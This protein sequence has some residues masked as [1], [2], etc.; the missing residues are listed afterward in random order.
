MA[1]H[2]MLQMMV[3]F[4]FINSTSFKNTQHC[5]WITGNHSVKYI[6]CFEEVGSCQDVEVYWFDY[7]LYDFYNL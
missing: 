1:Q 6:Q 3:F 2:S 5:N 7:H 4:N